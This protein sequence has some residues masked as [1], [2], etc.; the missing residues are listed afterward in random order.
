VT[1]ESDIV[2]RVMLWTIILLPI[3]LWVGFKL[4]ALA[5]LLGL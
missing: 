1:G 2:E 4:Q 5:L 3:A